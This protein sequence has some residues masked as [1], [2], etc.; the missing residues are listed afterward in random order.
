M[1]NLFD[2]SSLAMIPTA[3]KDGKLYSVRPTPEYG[4]ELVTNGD[5]SS[6]S[7][8]IIN[9]NTGTSTQITGGYLQIT[10][11]GAFTTA[12]QSGVAQIGTSYKLRYE[13]IAT[14]GGQLGLEIGGST[15]LIP[16]TIGI[17]TFYYTSNSTSLTLKRYTGALDIKIDNVSVKEV[18]VANGDFDFSRGSNLAA[19]RVDVNGLIEKGRENLNI[20][21]DPLDAQK[22]STSYASVTYQDNYN[23]NLG[24]LLNNAIVFVDNSTTRYAYYNNAVVSGTLYTL[25]VF[26]IMDDNSVPVPATDFLI[27]LGGASIASGYS[28]EDYGNN[29]YRVSV[30]GISGASNTASGILKVASNSTKGFRIS[31]FQVEQGLVA[32]P[33]IKTTGTTVKA[34]ILEDLPRLDYSASCPSLLLEPQRS[35][36]V[37]DYSGYT[38]DSFNGAAISFT[39][40]ERSPEG[41]TNAVT[42]TFGG[43]SGEVVQRSSISISNST[44]YTISGYF[45]LTSGTLTSGS[46]QIKGLDGLSGG[47]VSLNTLTDEW[48]RL[49]FSVTSS[50]TSGRVQLRCDNSATIQVYGLQLESGSY[51]TSVIP[52]YGSAVTRSQDICNKTGVTDLIGQSEGTMFLDFVA[53]DDDAF[54]IIYQVRTTGST[55][56]GQIDFRIQSGNLRVLGNDAGTNQFNI[57]AGAAIAG[58]R[59]KC[60]VRYATNDVAFYVNGVLKGTDANASFSSSTLSQITFN[61]NG[62]NFIPNADVKQAILFKTGLTNAELASITTI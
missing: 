48:Q 28:V 16:S 18:L 61:E 31:G 1:S 4:A 55:N 33:Y 7:D 13:V 17:H 47:S 60:A 39:G 54:Q 46:N 44:T 14:D 40:T 38:W 10:T 12:T 43:S 57:N 41:F 49:T 59:Y 5:F 9:N 32:T 20:Y 36:L 37:D 51:E 62:S 21:S 19:T 8:W 29:V 53:N 58:T 25:S 34:G 35:N 23:W 22:G 42:W 52:T 6:A 56:V 50:S 30:Y 2:F 3:Y 11:N 24:S 26:M 45:K 27:V 15:S